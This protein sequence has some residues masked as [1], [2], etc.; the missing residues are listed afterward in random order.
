MITVKI[1]VEFDEKN[2]PGTRNLEDA[3]MGIGA[4]DITINWMS[5]PYSGEE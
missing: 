3:L 1:N 5:E 2:F 4:E